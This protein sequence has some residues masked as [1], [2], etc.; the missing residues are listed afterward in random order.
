M[1]NSMRRTVCLVSEQN[2]HKNIQRWLESMQ[3]SQW[4]KCNCVFKIILLN[5]YMVFSCI[6]SSSLNHLY[7]F[8][9]C[10]DYSRKIGRPQPVWKIWISKG[11]CTVPAINISNSICSFCWCWFQSSFSFYQSRQHSS[12]PYYAWH[13]NAWLDGRKM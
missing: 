9:V 13:D 3:G 8:I 4:T 12:I 2:E 5:W 6:W 10:L 1:G 11:I 7:A